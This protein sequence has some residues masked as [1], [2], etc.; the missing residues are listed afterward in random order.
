LA[1]KVEESPKRVDKVITECV[2]L[3]NTSSQ[4]GRL[5]AQ[6]KLSS[7]AG[8]SSSN[9]TSPSTISPMSSSKVGGTGGDGTMDQKGEEFMKLKERILLLERIH[10]HTIGF[11]L[12]VEHPYKFIVEQVKK[13]TIGRKLRYKP[14]SSAAASAN[15]LSPSQVVG[16]MSTEIMQYSVN[17]ANDS[18]STSLCLQFGPQQIATACLFMACCFADIEPSGGPD[19]WMEVLDHPDLE[20]LVSICDQILDT[21]DKKRGNDVNKTNKIRTMLDVWRGSATGGGVGGSDTSS[22]HPAP[23]LPT[24]ASS[25]K[26][27]KTDA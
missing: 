6:P 23:S 27:L 14:D 13:L 10:L 15:K 17:F 20:A 26:R 3:K 18:L 21:L 1:A 8:G 9:A 22:K 5:S 7:G 19:E 12:F 24:G 16:K 25:P 2:E 11:D 4:S